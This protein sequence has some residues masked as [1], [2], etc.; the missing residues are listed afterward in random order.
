MVKDNRTWVHPNAIRRGEPGKSGRYLHYFRRWQ[1]FTVKMDDYRFIRWVASHNTYENP[2]DSA[3]DA[4]A[5]KLSEQGWE[6][7]NK[8]EREVFSQH[9]MKEIGADALPEGIS[10]EGWGRLEGGIGRESITAFAVDNDPNWR[11]SEYDE[12]YEKTFRNIR[13]S[14]LSAPEEHFGSM[15]VWD[16]SMLEISRADDMMGK[17]DALYVCFYM[18][19]EKL[20]AFAHDVVTQQIRPT[21]TLNAQSLLFRDEVDSALSELWHPREYI[22]IYGH[23][24]PAILNSIRFDLQTGAIRP[25]LADQI[26]DEGIAALVEHSA[27]PAA[28]GMAIPEAFTKD[29]HGLKR[30]LW[31]LAAAI[32]LAAL[33]RW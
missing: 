4:V 32:V 17:D 31:L 30:A 11:P 20:K 8:E 2:K 29:L 26:I 27:R 22:M 13:I 14:V 15:S 6:A 3:F 25:P 24:H 5:K 33:I 10:L 18:L 19:P 16:K 1:H 23:N 21:L 12:D 9:Q 28:T 7:L